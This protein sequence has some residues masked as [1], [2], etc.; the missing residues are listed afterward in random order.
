MQNRVY[1]TSVQQMAYRGLSEMVNASDLL[2]ELQLQYTQTTATEQQS[3][4]RYLFL[5]HKS[6]TVKIIL[7]FE[8]FSFRLL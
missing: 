2:V 8:Q 7:S 1:L 4:N 3:A 6:I 5:Q